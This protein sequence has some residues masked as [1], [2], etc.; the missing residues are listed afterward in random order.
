[1]V[2]IEEPDQKTGKFA[3]FQTSSFLFSVR[4]QILE[5]RS[6]KNRLFSFSVYGAIEG[7]SSWMAEPGTMVIQNEQ[8]WCGEKVRSITEHITE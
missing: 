1:M 4:L 6:G 5:K 3:N 2:D 8:K 7:N